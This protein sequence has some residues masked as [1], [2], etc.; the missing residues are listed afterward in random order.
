VYYEVYRKAKKVDM[1]ILK[2]ITVKTRKHH[3]CSACLWMYVPGTIMR[4]VTNVYEGDFGTWREC[5][6]CMELLKKYPKRF[7]DG[8]GIFE[9]GCVDECLNKGQTS[10]E[11]LIELNKEKI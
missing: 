3:R 5:P 2:D 4:T 11:L 10:E 8:F 6:A 9:Y 7:D 1:R